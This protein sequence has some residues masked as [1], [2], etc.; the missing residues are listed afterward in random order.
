MKTYYCK[1]ILDIYTSINNKIS[2]CTTNWLW[3]KYLNVRQHWTQYLCQSLHMSMSFS[4]SKFTLLIFICVSHEC[5]EQ[6]SAFDTKW[7][8]QLAIKFTSLHIISD[9]QRTEMMLRYNI[10]F[11][12]NFS[13]IKVSSTFTLYSHYWTP[14]QCFRG[15]ISIP[16][17]L[18]NNRIHHKPME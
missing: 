4:N 1:V 17:K 5:I 8:Y 13:S 6:M 9:P 18:S 12:H 15:K 3:Y 2:I 11:I 7:Q 10:W 14:I 16:W